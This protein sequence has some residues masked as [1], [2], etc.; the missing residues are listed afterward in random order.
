MSSKGSLHNY[1]NGFLI[2]FVIT[3][4][5]MKTM[6]WHPCSPSIHQVAEEKGRQVT[7]DCWNCVYLIHFRVLW[8]AFGCKIRGHIQCWAI[9]AEEAWKCINT[10]PINSFWLLFEWNQN[11]TMKPYLLVSKCRPKSSI[12]SKY[13]KICHLRVLRSEDS[14]FSLL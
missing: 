3:G 8:A 7:D 11:L 14:E 9:V 1:K 4:T 12:R 5:F 10:W 2:N 6:A 13:R